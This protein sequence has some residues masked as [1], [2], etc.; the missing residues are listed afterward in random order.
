ASPKATTHPT[1]SAL[2]ATAPRSIFAD[3]RSVAGS[4]HHRIVRRPPRATQAAPPRSSAAAAPTYSGAG[5]LL[6]ATR[7]PTLN[8][9]ADLRRERSLGIADASAWFLQGKTT[10][11]KPPRAPDGDVPA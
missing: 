11:R 2:A 8:V 5:C 4:A 6:A 10:N 9:H 7:S 1:S 3:E